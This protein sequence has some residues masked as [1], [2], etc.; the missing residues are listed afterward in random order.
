MCPP[1]GNDGVG[2][3]GAVRVWLLGGFRVSVGPGTIEQDQWQLRKAAAL[4]K[5]L[6]LSTGHR[7]HREQAMDALWP[8]SS[9]KAACQRPDRSASREGGGPHPD[10]EGVLLRVEEHVADQREGGGRQRGSGAAEHGACDDQH[11]RAVGKNTSAPARAG[12]R[13][14]ATVESP[15]EKRL[16]A[17]SRATKGGKST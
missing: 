17:V 6:A 13:R 4:V 2:Q 9:R 10:G 7:L 8:D 5:L 3:S 11:L 15:S 1:A 12:K 14:K 16:K